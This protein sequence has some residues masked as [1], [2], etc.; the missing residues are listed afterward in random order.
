MVSSSCD[1]RNVFQLTV[2]TCTISGVSG[3]CRIP[4]NLEVA[5]RLM[6]MRIDRSAAET[7]FLFEISKRCSPS[8]NEYNMNAPIYEF[9]D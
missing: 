3:S 5:R 7:H 1:G 9:I 4:V 8:N 2:S 6:G